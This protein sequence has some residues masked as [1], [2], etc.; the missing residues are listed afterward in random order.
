[1]LTT[2]EAINAARSK[3]IEEV[4]TISLP[5]HNRL[6]M[7][8]LSTIGAVIDNLAWDENGHVW[9]LQANPPARFFVDR[10][11]GVTALWV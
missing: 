8:G 4:T 5:I 9:N 6:E 10:P 3:F 1:M 2:P 11:E 7:N